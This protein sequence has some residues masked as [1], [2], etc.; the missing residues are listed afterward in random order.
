M[1]I[2]VLPGDGIGP[3]ITAEAVRVLNSLDL[4]FEMEEALL[5]GGA[6]DATGNPYPEATQKLAREADAVLLGAVGGP[7][8]DTLPREKRPE[9]GLLGIRKDLNLFANLRPA[10]LY[11]ELANASTLKP[12]VVAGL[13]ILI[14]RELTGD[15]YFGQPRGIREENGERVGF[16]TM[17]YSESEIRRIG[18]VAFQSAQKRNRK[19]CSVDKMNVLECTQLWRDVMIEISKEYPDVELSHML[20]DNAAMQLVKAPKQFDVMVTG[21]M[22]GDILSDEASMLTGSIGMLPSASLDDKNKG[23]YEP[24]HGSAPDIAGKGVANPLAT[25]LSVAMMLRYTFGL[26]EQA[27][28]VENAVKKV[29]AQGFRTGD[30][31]ERGTNK[32]GT[33][34]MGDAV[35]AALV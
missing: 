9:R 6:V 29:L 30:I 4:K 11:P 5:G 25:I 8:W 26:E 20:V 31:Y 34:E 13:D 15:I 21:N 23:L 33:R 12:E 7:Q 32:V 24:S 35:L 3:E 2:C 10:I 27:V 17:V 19:L 18:H 1:K 14:V 16:N 28:R 22:F